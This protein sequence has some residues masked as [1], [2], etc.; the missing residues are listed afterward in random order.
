MDVPAASASAFDD[1]SWS[2]VTLPHT[3]NVTD[4]ET[5]GYYQGPGWYRRHYAVP[6]AYTGHSLYLQFDGA[7]KVTDV[8]VNGTQVG[9]HRGGNAIFRF[10]VTSL[11]HI[12]A[13]NVIAVK[14]DNSGFPDVPPIAISGQPWPDFTQF[15]GLYRDVHLLA[16][17]SVHVDVLD[18]ASP[19]VF[20]TPKNVG[21]AS[22]DLDVRVE[23]ANDDALPHAVDVEADVI[24]ANQATVKKLTTSLMLLPTAAGTN[25][26]VT[27]TTT[28]PSP[29]LWNGRA[30]PYLYT[31]QVLVKEAGVVR[32]AI[33]QPLGFRFYSIDPKAGFLLNGQYL[34][35]HGVNRHQERQGMGWALTSKEH[36][37]DM[38]LIEEIGATVVR[39]CH[40]EQAQYFHDLADKNGILLWA[41]LGFV[42]RDT[43][44]TAFDQNTSQQL[45]ELIRQSYNHPSIVVWSIMNEVGANAHDLALLPVLDA[46]AHSEDPTR[47]TTLGDNASNWDSR[48]TLADTV[49]FNYYSGWYTGTVDAVGP[50]L[51]GL[52]QQKP[53]DPLALSEFGAGAS[54][55]TH[56]ATPTAMPNS[57]NHPEEF[58]NV[59]HEAYWGILKTRPFV[60]GKFVFQMFDIA[61]AQRMEGDTPGINDKGLVT[62]DHHTKKDVFFFY[63]ANWSADPFVY[64]TSRRFEPRTVATTDIKV[65]A[66]TDSVALTLNGAAL[67]L[68]TSADHVFVWPA[69]T[70]ANGT[71]TVNAV[72]TKAGASTYADTVTWTLQ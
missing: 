13:D 45:T 49:G 56:S 57:T 12:G 11:L 36:D 52:H 15:G 28:I 18:Y 23:L 9:E 58:Q 66:N 14:V 24:D 3:W 43:Q 16:T 29:H 61:S 35:L 20:V 48:S 72:G 67:G 70:L 64:I 8:F 22:S 44:S 46:L 27:L 21:A 71:N 2:P 30:D 50:F 41:E 47:P 38:A 7:C 31:V 68:K 32:D 34:D 40:Y 4:G 54:I 39:L 37:Q 63:K 62:H 60:W 42:S 1:A 33:S 26:S 51:D 59:F 6:S 53:A 10:D 65:Y 69:V 17:A 25:T 5:L 19:G 55:A